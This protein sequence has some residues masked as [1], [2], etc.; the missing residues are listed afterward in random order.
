MPAE[1]G[2]WKGEIA[3]RRELEGKNGP[4][5]FVSIRRQSS[6]HSQRKVRISLIH[7]TGECWTRPVI[8]PSRATG[9]PS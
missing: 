8:V 1:G 5:I 2:L 9:K 6:A 3:C 7:P 4:L